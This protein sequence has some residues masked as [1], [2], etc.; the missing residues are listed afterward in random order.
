MITNRIHGDDLD[1]FLVRSFSFSSLSESS[2]VIAGSSFFGANCQ[3]L[4]IVSSE[5]VASVFER[6]K[7]LPEK[8][9]W[10]RWPVFGPVNI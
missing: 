9:R 4:K 6:S 2:E 8:A 10:P 1:V 7:P 3:G 5:P